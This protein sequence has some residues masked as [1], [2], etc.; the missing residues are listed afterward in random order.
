MNTLRRGAKGAVVKSLQLWFANFEPIVADGDFGLATERT[1][2]KLQEK[3]GLVADGVVGPK[4]AGRF[5]VEGWLPAGFDQPSQAGSGYPP[6]PTSYSA[7]TQTQKT[8]KF[9][10]PGTVP[11]NP[12]PGGPIKKDA[13][14]AKRIVRLKLQDWFP[15]V[16]GVLVVDIHESVQVQWTSLF[17]ELITKKKAGVVLSCAGAWNPR[18]VRGSTQT[19]SSHAYATAIDFNAPENWLGAE[20]AKRGQAG[21]LL[22]MVDLLAARRMW[23]GGWFARVDGMHIECTATD[24][25]LGLV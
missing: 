2:K 4:S 18:F 17:D 21:C 20:P 1:T 6:K 7:L 12:E 8:K 19:F 5:M 24:A 3:F 14:F 11:A 9:G 15:S 22:D 23:W 13:S 25:E 16:T 10:S